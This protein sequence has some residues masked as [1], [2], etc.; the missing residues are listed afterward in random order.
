MLLTSL[1]LSINTFGQASVDPDNGCLIFM[2]NPI[3]DEP[4]ACAGSGSGCHEIH[5]IC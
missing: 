1:S 5:I 4:T 3:E 2:F